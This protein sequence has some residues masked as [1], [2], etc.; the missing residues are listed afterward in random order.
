MLDGVVLVDEFGGLLRWKFMSCSHCQ[1]LSQLADLAS[2]WLF[3]LV[4]TQSEAR[5]LVDTTL[6]NDYNS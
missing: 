1:E 5:L 6:D 4:N 3:T 2:H